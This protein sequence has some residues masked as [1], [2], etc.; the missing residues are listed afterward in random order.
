MIGGCRRSVELAEVAHGLIG[1][2]DGIDFGEQKKSD[3]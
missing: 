1:G 2:F 3:S